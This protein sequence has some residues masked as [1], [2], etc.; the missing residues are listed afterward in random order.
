VGRPGAGLSELSSDFRAALRR[1]VREQADEV[2]G[3]V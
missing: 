1:F 2:R 3:V